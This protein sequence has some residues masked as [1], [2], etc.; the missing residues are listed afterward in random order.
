MLT[1]R[2]VK[3]LQGKDTR[4]TYVRDK[5]L[6]RSGSIRRSLPLV[7]YSPP[8]APLTPVFVGKVVQ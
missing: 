3:N 8:L 6:L 2:P 7:L 1:A 5:G 4:F